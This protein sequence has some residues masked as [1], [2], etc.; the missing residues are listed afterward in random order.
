MAVASPRVAERPICSR[1][2]GPAAGSDCDLTACACA[3]CAASRAADY[4][5]PLHGVVRACRLRR[6]EVTRPCPRAPV[7]PC[8]RARVVGIHSPSSAYL[9][10][11]LKPT[12][13]RALV[14]PC[15]RAPHPTR[16][17]P[18]AF[19]PARCAPLALVGMN[20]PS[21]YLVLTL[22]LPC[23]YL[24]LTLF[25]PCSYLVLTREGALAPSFYY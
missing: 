17:P 22:F 15:P 21:A 19:R 18:R 9:V 1:R 6:D 12:C 3:R 20:T 13:P 24:V 23:S 16:L 4:R 11:T 10:L 8:P 7:A 2:R 25:L 14:L 5:G